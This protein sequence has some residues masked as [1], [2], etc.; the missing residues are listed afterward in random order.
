M[1]GKKIERAFALNQDHLSWLDEMTD[2][3][4]L[5]D[6]Q[7]ALRIVLDF[8]IEEG[9]KDHIFKTVRCRRCGG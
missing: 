6:P 4:A 5:A 1:A 9:D 7:K 8:C 2:K 3:Y